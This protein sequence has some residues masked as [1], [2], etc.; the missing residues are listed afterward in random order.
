MSGGVNV[1]MPLVKMGTVVTGPGAA[2]V[3]GRTAA[4]HGVAGVT[5]ALNHATSNEAKVS[6]PRINKIIE[7]L[8]PKELKLTEDDL[9]IIKT[10]SRNDIVKQEELQREARL[11]KLL[12]YKSATEKLG[13]P[14]VFY[15]ELHNNSGAAD[16]VVG[17]YVV[18]I[19]NLYEESGQPEHFALGTVYGQPIIYIDAKKV[20]HHE[21]INLMRR[22]FCY[23]NDGKKSDFGANQGLRIAVHALSELSGWDKKRKELYLEWYRMST[24]IET[25]FEEAVVL[26]QRFHDDA[27]NVDDLFPARHKEKLRQLADRGEVL[28]VSSPKINH[29]AAGGTTRPMA[30]AAEREE[31][32]V[33][34]GTLLEDDVFEAVRFILRRAEAEGRGSRTPQERAKAILDSNDW[35]YLTDEGSM[36]HSIGVLN[37][38]LNSIKQGVQRN[39]LL[40]GMAGA[41]ADS[42]VLDWVYEGVYEVNNDDVRID[43]GFDRGN[44]NITVKIGGTSIQAGAV[45]SDRN[46]LML[47]SVAWQ[48]RFNRDGVDLTTEEVVDTIM[49]EIDRAIKAGN[50]SLES[51]GEIGISFAGPL[52]SETGVVGTPFKSPNLP[53]DNY[54]LKAELEKRLKARYR[55]ALSVKLSNDG[56]ASVVG[57]CTARGT[58]YQGDRTGMYF[59]LG[60]GI[61]GTAVVLGDVQLGP[62]GEIREL[63]HT[64]VA[65]SLAERMDS[66]S[67]P[68]YRYLGR[69][70]KGDHPR[71]IDG[72]LVQGDFEDICSGPN[73]DRRWQAKGYSLEGIAGTRNITQTA[74]DGDRTAI[75]LIKETGREIGGAFAAF[76]AAYPNTEF[77]NRI[78][79]G[80]GVGENLGEGVFEE[81]QSDD[82]FITAVKKSV[83]E[84]LSKWREIGSSRAK[85]IASGIRRSILRGG[86]REFLAFVP[87]KK[88]A[89]L[90][91]SSAPAAQPLFIKIGGERIYLG[92]A[93]ELKREAGKL[94]RRILVNR[95]ELEANLDKLA[96][97]FNGR[98][99]TLEEAQRFVD[100]H[101]TWHIVMF[102]VR[103]AVKEGKI[104]RN[105]A[106][107]ILAITS[108]QEEALGN[109]VGQEFSGQK[110]SIP[111]VQARII[112]DVTIV[113][114][115]LLINKGKRTIELLKLLK[116]NHYKPGDPNSLEAILR[117]R[118]GIDVTVELKTSAQIAR[119]KAD[120]DAAGGTTMPM[121]VAAGTDVA[122]GGLV[123]SLVTS[124]KGSFDRLA[125]KNPKMK[126][127]VDAATD[128]VRRWLS[129]E[130]FS[131][132][133]E[134]LRELIELATT[135]DE[136]ANEL[137]DSFWRVIPFGTGGRRWRVGI[138]PNRMNPYMV[139]LTAQGHANYLL[140]NYDND[141]VCRRGVIAAHDVRKFTEFFPQTPAL[142]RYL[143]V[144]KEK[145]PTVYGID[146]KRFSEIE[147][148]VYAG[149]GIRF[150][151][152]DAVR[153]TPFLSFLVW[154]LH[155]I[156]N[157]DVWRE[158]NEARAKAGIVNSSSHNQP[159]NNGTKFYEGDG[160]QAPPAEAQIIVNA[161]NAVAV[162]NRFNGTL[163]DAQ[164]QGL[165]VCLSGDLL[166]KCDDA[167]FAAVLD[168]LNDFVPRA[169]RIAEVAFHAL[170][171][172]GDTNAAE[173]LKRAGFAVL[174]DPNDAHHHSFPTA[175]A[176]TPNPE[177]ERSFD[178]PIAVGV[179]RDVDFFIKRGV[180]V[181]AD[182][183]GR[184]FVVR[185]ADV[186]DGIMADL[187][188]CQIA[189]CTD[190]DSDR[191]GLAIKV[192]K[193]EANGDIR[194]RWISANDNDEIAI[195][196]FRYILEK[197]RALGRLQKGKTGV[198]VSTVVSNN[199]EKIIIEQLAHEYGVDIKVVV[200]TVGFKHTGQVITNLKNGEFKGV[201]G[202]MMRKLAIDTTK[203]YFIASFEEG[204]GGLIGDQGSIDKDSAPSSVVLAML[205]SEMQAQGKTVYDY[206][207]ETYKKFGYSKISLDPIVMDGADG[208][209]MIQAIMKVFR[210]P[211]RRPRAIAGVGI[212]SVEDLLEIYPT[213]IPAERADRDT[214]VFTLE[215]FTL[216]DGTQIK[217]AKIIVRPSGT[218]PKIKISASVAASALG[219]AASNEALA[220]QMDSVNKAF[221]MLLDGALLAA[222][223]AS[224]AEYNGVK[225]PQDTVGRLQL[226]RLYF[227]MPLRQKLGI[228]FPLVKRIQELANAVSSNQKTLQTAQMEV[229]Q[230]L[231][232]LHKTNGVDYVAE[233]F[234]INLADQIAQ[235][236]SEPGNNM[237]SPE[238]QK[239]KLQAQ[240]LFGVEKG[241]AVFNELWENA[242]LALTTSAIP[243]PGAP[244]AAPAAAA[245]TASTEGITS[246]ISFVDRMFANA[247]FW[248]EKYDS[249]DADAANKDEYMRLALACVVDA[250][251]AL[252][253]TPDANLGDNNI[254]IAK[255][256][257]RRLKKEGKFEAIRVNYGAR[258]LLK[259]SKLL[260][261]IENG[262]YGEALKQAVG[263]PVSQQAVVV[264][265]PVNKAIEKAITQAQTGQNTVAARNIEQAFR[266]MQQPEQ[267]R[268]IL[269]REV[270]TILQK[271]GGYERLV[272]VLTPYSDHQLV[273]SKKLFAD[274]Q[275][276]I[277]RERARGKNVMEMSV[278]DILELYSDGYAKTHSQRVLLTAEILAGKMGVS[279]K[280][281]KTLEVFC[282][283]HALATPGISDR[284]EAQK[285]KRIRDGKREPL[286]SRENRWAQ[287]VQSPGQ[288]VVD[289]LNRLGLNA[290]EDL[291]LLLRYHRF[292]RRIELYTQIDSS[293]FKSALNLAP[294][295]LKLILAIFHLANVIQTGNNRFI[296]EDLRDG[297]TENLEGT[298][299]FSRGLL[300]HEDLEKG[301]VS[302]FIELLVAYNEDLINLIIN[303]RERRSLRGDDIV[304]LLTQQFQAWKDAGVDSELAKSAVAI[305]KRM[306]KD[307]PI[308]V[309]SWISDAKKAVGLNSAQ[310][311]N[312]DNILLLS[313]EKV[314][315]CPK[316]K[317]V[318]VVMAGGSGT[319]F[320]PLG[321][322]D[323]PKQFVE[324]PGGRKLIEMAI[325]RLHD[326]DGPGTI[327]VQTSQR[328]LKLVNKI[329]E[330]YPEYK[331]GR[332]KIYG[333]SAYADNTAALYYALARIE[334]EI[335]SDVVVEMY[336]ADHIIPEEDRSAYHQAMQDLADE[337]Y[338]YPVVGVVGIK[339]TRDAPGEFGHLRIT[340]NIPGSTNCALRFT[341]KPDIEQIKTW[342]SEGSYDLNNPD[343]MQFLWNA[344]YFSA[345]LS[346]WFEALQ[347]VAGEQV[348][349]RGVGNRTNNYYA[350]SQR[351]RDVLKLN[352]KGNDPEDI[353][354]DI[355]GIMATWKA[356]NPASLD[357]VVAEPLSQDQTPRVGLVACRG[358]F[359]WRDV[360]SLGELAV[361]YKERGAA[362]IDETENNLVTKGRADFKNCQEVIVFGDTR[363]GV[364]IEGLN[365]AY[366]VADGDVIVVV[367]KGD[368]QKVK[369]IYKEASRYRQT[370]QYAQTRGEPTSVD[371]KNNRVV[372]DDNEN[373]LV[374]D[375]IALNCKNSILY[376]ER[377]LVSAYGI[378]GVIIIR[379]GN[380]VY[381]LGGKKAAEAKAKGMDKVITEIQA[382][383]AQMRAIEEFRRNPRAVR[384]DCPVQHYAWGQKGDDAAIARLLGK[385]PG[386]KPWAE[387]WLGAHP[388]APA[389]AIINVDGQDVRVP[390]DALIGQAQTAVIGR[391]SDGLLY[392]MKML[393]AK[394]ILSLQGH[395]NKAQAKAG[396]ARENAAG[397]AIDAP[398]RNY[399]DANH[400]P[401]LIM[402]L[403]DFYALR[404]FRPVAI[405]GNMLSFLGHQEGRFDD[406]IKDDV[407]ILRNESNSPD[408]RKAALKRIYTTIMTM[409]Q[410]IVNKICSFLETDI[411]NRAKKQQLTKDDIDYWV[412]RAIEQYKQ[413]DNYNRGIIIMILLNLVHLKPGKA[414]YLPAGELHAYLEGEGVEVMVSSDNVVRGGLT[415]KHVDVDQL[416][417]VLTFDAGEPEILEGEV[418]GVERIYK[419]PAEE[420]EL[421]VITVNEENVYNAPTDHSADMLLVMDGEVSVFEG[422]REHKLS[423]GSVLLVPAAS[424]AYTI[425]GKGTIY[426]T[427]V[428]RADRQGGVTNGD[429]SEQA[430]G[431]ER[432]SSGAASN[433]VPTA[434]PAASA[435]AEALRAGANPDTLAEF[436]D[437]VPGEEALARATGIIATR[438]KSGVSMDTDGPQSH[439]G[440]IDLSGVRMTVIG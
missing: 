177:I 105:V 7:T 68:K 227:N 219:E 113:L 214:L 136:I 378:E 339:P 148:E 24:W 364:H 228:Y 281:K 207:M 269:I 191:S 22:K 166:K 289:K 111:Y 16:A 389:V 38:A 359:G 353:A 334:H 231:Q 11:N 104:A 387:L 317:R 324:L 107:K 432:G 211:S 84:E 196:L 291:K 159:D 197:Y 152:M 83:E 205:A 102:M 373:T 29:A 354:E 116:D 2:R 67:F 434:A 419:T 278:E 92:L 199:L 294:Q 256:V 158:A 58:L 186:Y 115:E 413:G 261:A 198:A 438:Y 312:I 417:E 14:R 162:I 236:I 195:I 246:E 80:S 401:E 407:A 284:E 271:A 264:V 372:K 425:R 30:V 361:L 338:H 154:N 273:Y 406:L 384:L 150:Y 349:Y 424:N 17:A 422:G 398:D 202:E 217:D 143:E 45:D 363:L 15:F 78:V 174:R 169:S 393:T 402:A 89:T 93:T 79:L 75:E 283:L 123:D 399:K 25:N 409:D 365:N 71:N 326:N 257:L 374:N 329:A 175:F 163:A 347:D 109:V 437:G 279:K 305:I 386:D 134:A 108:D 41:D 203:A 137:F 418:A 36:P 262:Q 65:Y 145:C 323:E 276:Y 146:S 12:A 1:V 286:T 352:E 218:E 414:M 31:R 224:E 13:D 155:R 44:V 9:A 141:D 147:A 244:P 101:E 396:F 395:P 182:L 165:V 225:V 316:E 416:L 153:T 64:L 121:A 301:T 206:L 285:F 421:S 408:E 332:L 94:D 321:R 98:T 61:N 96:V 346:V 213:E 122:A 132:Y 194:V 330:Q 331:N 117:D 229:A 314:E 52:N 299:E 56:D 429:G 97:F 88:Q 208:F 72:S 265:D 151:Y 51:I 73:L 63:G 298:I 130:Q 235:I 49:G 55:V 200:H 319:R 140:A 54:L 142:K 259:V 26:E 254:E 3:I 164:A 180:A 128:N 157:D 48:Q 320:W 77:V 59:I 124:A 129:E 66:P 230:E 348:G 131:E 110:P 118:L 397:K 306:A 430:G 325:D 307:Y 10:K 304:W 274:I 27:P 260:E 69:I 340:R 388:N 436:L 179:K 293:D 210:D 290:P 19:D 310:E 345:R 248:L 277:K 35:Y 90:T 247:F 149:N 394:Q 62:T 355:F 357:Y 266:E 221:R 181:T 103:Q 439:L 100:G 242:L 47:S 170:N 193:E 367:G 50:L 95:T 188:V 91:V 160:G 239:I 350:L 344:G 423:K 287:Y 112:A 404:G 240:I 216:P 201:V 435:R 189:L 400:K 375:T 234:K 411:S 337:A 238:A 60:T 302:N 376:A 263:Y 318:A 427:S 176:N 5:G 209:G 368:D 410:D 172:T 341:E 358:K 267:I 87:A 272:D 296:R 250:I 351:Y 303:A 268:A 114:N 362:Y 185:A 270:L 40:P 8:L 327:I 380:D 255:S 183:D 226:V 37:R 178:L 85:Q 295:D 139:A 309:K 39:K 383:R 245:P 336:P 233:A 275:V 43:R 297:S 33:A 32:K 20:S 6:G 328:Y 360:G 28:Q 382:E 161:G 300:R 440:G 366:V 311:T 76:V 392:L 184:G 46:L 356:A 4:T 204:E 342:K 173:T 133:Q 135:N 119:I 127:F 21:R 251:I 431:S 125:L 144:I 120:I 381:V 223:D 391:G 42:R 369:D 243:G 377:G 415:P 335:G 379:L 282:A 433:G 288:A 253:E 371:R 343:R 187:R 167:Y 252:K 70:T 405:L 156:L 237:T 412:L 403:G 420:F 57:E 53:F 322:E 313:R 280:L 106:E 308:Y 192:I 168:P 390:L 315:K 220:A 171:G 222:Y 385:D 18:L 258:D 81:G 190:P 249:S 292:K 428:P 34:T 333:E 215:D 212:K 138:G 241:E 99:P 82:I 232:K 126:P 86:E 23:L 426:K 74:R 370:Q